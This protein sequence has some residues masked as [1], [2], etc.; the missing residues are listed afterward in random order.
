MKTLFIAAVLAIT[1]TTA[2]ANTLKPLFPWLGQG[3]VKKAACWP[4]G[5]L[6]S[7]LASTNFCCRSCIASGNLGV[8]YCS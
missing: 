7:Y 6:C 4:S 1:A 2:N 3:Q 8:G 5:T